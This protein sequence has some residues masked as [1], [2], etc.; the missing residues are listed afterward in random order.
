MRR[1]WELLQPL[2]TFESFQA[3][4]WRLE[5]L[6]SVVWETQT[7]RNHMGAQSKASPSPIMPW[8]TLFFEGALNWSPLMPASRAVVRMVDVEIPSVVA[9]DVIYSALEL[10]SESFEILMS[11]YRAKF[12]VKISSMF[13]IDVQLSSECLKFYV[14]LSSVWS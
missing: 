7:S 12:Y 6:S 14:K 8:W 3:L 4:L 5:H 11:N 10:S 1:F 13:E 2:H 9:I